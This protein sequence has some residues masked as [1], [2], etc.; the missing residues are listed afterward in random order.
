[1]AAQ[2]VSYRAGHG[3]RLWQDILRGHGVSDA[4]FDTRILE[5]SRFILLPYGIKLRHRGEGGAAIA[6]EARD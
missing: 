2:K 1:M 4:R 5:A 6:S 3:I